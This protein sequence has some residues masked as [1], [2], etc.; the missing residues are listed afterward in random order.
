MRLLFST[1]VAPVRT[2]GQESSLVPS[3]KYLPTYL[4]PRRGFRLPGSHVTYMLFRHLLSKIRLQLS[5]YFDTLH[6]SLHE[7]K[8][9][10]CFLQVTS[11]R[12]HLLNL[13]QISINM[14]E[15]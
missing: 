2:V 13:Y 15:F 7:F 1:Q 14:T 10:L 12:K 6:L 3:D 4:F 9:Y 11:S 5:L 8:F